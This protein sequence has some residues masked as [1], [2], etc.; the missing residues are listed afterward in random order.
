MAVG[1]ALMVVGPFITWVRV[2]LFGSL[3]LFSLLSAADASQAVAWFP[4]GVA[5]FVLLSSMSS[6]RRWLSRVVSVVGGLIVGLIGIPLA[7]DLA[8][9]VGQLGGLAELGLGSWATAGGAVLMFVGGAVDR[10]EI[11]R[12][13]PSAPA[14]EV[15]QREAVAEQVSPVTTISLQREG[16]ESDSA[17]VPADPSGG[18]SDAR[19]RGGIAGLVILIF[20]VG[21]IGWALLRE[22]REPVVDAATAGWATVA[23]ASSEDERPMV[24]APLVWTDQARVCWDIV[25]DL[26][27]FEVTIF[28]NEVSEGFKTRAAG[29]DCRYF[30]PSI[31]HATATECASVAG[32]HE[33]DVR[34]ELVVQQEQGEAYGLS[35]INSTRQYRLLQNP[36]TGQEF[37]EPEGFV[38]CDDGTYAETESDCTWFERQFE[39]YEPAGYPGWT[40]YPDTGECL[41]EEGGFVPE[42]EQ[43][44][45]SYCDRSG[46]YLDY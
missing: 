5:A 25:G 33:G 21:L 22:P 42:G 32:Y 12:A 10:S 18:M 19:K 14:R 31:S 2:P 24:E 26:E 34:W 27:S 17:A 11:D 7:V 37:E 30:S 3:N 38:E 15:A 16:S 39:S 28:A 8:N 4:I 45:G 23:T 35:G 43:P 36:C 20:S 44:V 13:R 9:E 29:R 1:A 6:S 41:H 40:C 46:C